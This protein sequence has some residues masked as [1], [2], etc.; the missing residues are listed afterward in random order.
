MLFFIQIGCFHRFLTGFSIRVLVKS[1]CSNEGYIDVVGKNY[2]SKMI[3]IP[4]NCC[5]PFFHTAFNNFLSGDLC[6]S[7]VRLQFAT[8][9]Q[10]GCVFFLLL[11]GSCRWSSSGE[12]H[13]CFRDCRCLFLLKV[14]LRLFLLSAFNFLQFFF[15]GLYFHMY[16]YILRDIIAVK[17][18]NQW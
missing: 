4:K 16:I 15:F 17:N 10:F 12:F 6:V 7:K 18:W 13:Q 8:M 2:S 14:L 9:R 3:L 11:L 5:V 1:L